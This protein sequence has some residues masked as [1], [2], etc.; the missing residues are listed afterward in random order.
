MK[1]IVI[2]YL[3]IVGAA[4]LAAQNT[5]L[6]LNISDLEWKLNEE[7]VEIS[8]KLRT[9]L[10][11]VKSGHHLVL[12]PYIF[13]KK[14]SLTLPSILVQGKKAET[15][16]KRHILTTGNNKKENFQFR[17]KTG[18]TVNYTTVVP[19][20]D[21]MSGGRLAI[22]ALD[23]SCCDAIEWGS[24][25]L[26][27]DLF[28]NKQQV[29]EEVIVEEVVKK[30]VVKNTTANKLA[31]DYRFLAPYFEFNPINT[32]S[33]EDVLTIYFRQGKDDIDRGYHNNNQSLVDLVS[34]IRS[35]NQSTDSRVS[36]VVISGFGSPE[37]TATFNEQLAESRTNILKEFVILNCPISS[38]QI[39]INKGWIDWLGLRTLVER[40]DMQDKYQVLDI[41]DNIPVWDASRKVGRLSTLMKLNGGIPYRYMLEKFFPL[42]R[43]TVYIKVYYN[44]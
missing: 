40:S 14:D 10:K 9:P 15:S 5:R 28:A 41:I 24:E 36:A 6:Q 26:A 23:I 39:Y 11:V 2:I 13:N 33:R 32:D 20:Q 37:G 31:A 3:L 17:G 38:E 12:Q 7:Q 18:Q 19:Y 34:A 1:R 29:E 44:N 21:W 43:N 4:S 30:G 8:F 42:L 35:V 16:E 27:V 25:N 22:Y